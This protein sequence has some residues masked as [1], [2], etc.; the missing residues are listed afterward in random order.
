[1]PTFQCSPHARVATV[2]LILIW[3]H[4]KTFNVA[5]MRGLQPAPAP[6]S[7]ITGYFQCS[8]HARVATTMRLPQYGQ[9]PFQCSPHARVATSFN[10][11]CI[12]GTS[13]QCSPHA[14][15][16]TSIPSSTSS[17]MLAFQCSPHARVATTRT[18]Q[19]SGCH[20]TFNVARMRGLQPPASARPTASSSFNVARMRGLQRKGSV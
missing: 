4:F 11:V 17:T 12:L 8:P 9:Y 18:H 5:R 1:M 10:R 15:V 13:F 16:A 6:S 3:F 20:S 19:R 14:R 7:S 2:V